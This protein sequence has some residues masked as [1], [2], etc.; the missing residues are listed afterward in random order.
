[1]SS[2]SVFDYHMPATD[3]M[4]NTNPAMAAEIDREAAAHNKMIA[5]QME[6]RERRLNNGALRKTEAFKKYPQTLKEW[7]QAEADVS[8]YKA[9][10]HELVRQLRDTLTQKEAA[11]AGDMEVYFRMLDQIPAIEQR[12]RESRDKVKT[13]MVTAE[14]KKAAHTLASKA[15][16]AEYSRLALPKAERKL[17]LLKEVQA[18]EEELKDLYEQSTDVAIL[19]K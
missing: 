1:M 19:G 12:I 9:Q 14:E 11:A 7:T 13:A 15:L 3:R 10:N 17:A 5:Q 6:Q 4:R 8:E 18:I 16:L 2:F